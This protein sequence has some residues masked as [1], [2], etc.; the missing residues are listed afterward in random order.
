MYQKHPAQPIDQFAGGRA[1]VSQTALPLEPLPSRRTLFFQLIDETA[2]A[3]VHRCYRYLILLRHLFQQLFAQCQVL[4]AAAG[5]LQS[6][7]QIP[8]A[9]VLILQAPS[10]KELSATVL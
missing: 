10:S 2:D 9:N 6:C 5:D 1:S 3:A 8:A 4:L 7:R